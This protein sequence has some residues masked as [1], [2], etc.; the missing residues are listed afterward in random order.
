MPVEICT[1]E[2][3][4]KDWLIAHDNTVDQ[5]WVE[6]CIALGEYLIAEREHQ[7]VG[8]LR[9]SRFWG[10]IPYMDM[11]RVEP[12]QQR[13][14]IGML[15]LGELQNI[16]VLHGAEI[17]MTSCETGEQEPLAW[18]LRQGFARTGEVNFPTVQDASEVF[19]VKRL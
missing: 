3:R 5:A 12:S 6:R 16:A 17:V 2:A 8:F 13:C 18:H 19:L 1:A 7:P 11:I 10:K 9:W 15:L 14:G 4:H